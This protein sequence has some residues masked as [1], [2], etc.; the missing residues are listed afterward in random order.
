MPFVLR[1]TLNFM[2]VQSLRSDYAKEYLLEQFQS[3][4]LQKEILRQT[5][6]VDTPS[7]NGVDVRKN[8]HLL[9]TAKTL[10]FQMHMPKH[11]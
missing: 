6:C 10:L 4:M 8:R 7:Q 9:E 11:F 3:F 1:F 5:S 2:C